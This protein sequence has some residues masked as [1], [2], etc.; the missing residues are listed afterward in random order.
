MSWLLFIVG[1]FI[2]GSVQTAT[3]GVF[4]D[5][6]ACM[7]K[8]RETNEKPDTPPLMWSNAGCLQIPTPEARKQPSR[9]V[10]T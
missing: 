10:E 1:I 3:I 4:S 8:A 2:D 5:Q 9:W 6:Q 7:A